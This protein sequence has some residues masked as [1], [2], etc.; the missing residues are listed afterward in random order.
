M[1]PAANKQKHRAT[2]PVPANLD[3]SLEDKIPVT[4]VTGFLGSGKTTLIRRA[5]DN[6]EFTDTAIIVNEFGEIGLDHHIIEESGE[7]TVLLGNGCLCCALEGDLVRALR[8]LLERR[9]QG[10]LP[11]YRRVMIET[12]GLADPEP[13]LMTLM[14]DPLRFSQYSLAGV[15]TVSDAL[16]GY[17]TLKSHEVARKQVALADRVLISK[18]DLAEPALATSLSA[19]LSSIGNAAITEL[20]QSHFDG[21]LLCDF[22][23]FPFSNT[24][25][26]L[27][28]TRSIHH[29]REITCV[30]RTLEHP[31]TLDRIECWV[32]CLLKN[33]GD[34]L[35]RL[36]AIFRLKDDH[37]LLIINAVH[38]VFYRPCFLEH[39]PEDFP[40]GGVTIIAERTT[41][42]DIETWI[43]RL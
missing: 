13:I 37:R 20:N 34:N 31:L 1:R 38:H 36:K 23:T 33:A 40:G 41:A 8:S 18:L 7:D 27:Q 2:L 39:V 24:N 17:A 26:D 35:L 4:V 5:L 10:K 9:E 15:I 29:N 28:S 12:S 30:S 6:P 22:P 3:L 14:S 16:N 21:S 25:S 42:Q 43:K 19:K 11:R 32:A